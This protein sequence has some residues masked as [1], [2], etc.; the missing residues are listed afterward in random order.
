MQNFF[1]QF[2]GPSQAP[3]AP[4][5][6]GVIMG[7]PKAPTPIQVR[8]QQLQE[9]SNAREGQKFNVS[10]E[11]TNFNQA[12]NLRKD[13]D[14]LQEVGF[15]KKIISSYAASVNTDETPEGDQLLINSYAQMLNPTSTVVL[16]EY[17]ATEQ[18]QTA[19]DQT[20]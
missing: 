11:D 20:Q 6:P 3:T 15:Y 8:D 13:F 7:R 5:A 10:Q 1:D 14:G 19:I 17:Q 18:N 4:Q 16:G 2:D 12:R 9:E